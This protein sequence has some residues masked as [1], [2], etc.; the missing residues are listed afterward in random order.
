MI[1]RFSISPKKYK[2]KNNFKKAFRE[3]TPGHKNKNKRKLV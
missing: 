1:N 3:D 2:N